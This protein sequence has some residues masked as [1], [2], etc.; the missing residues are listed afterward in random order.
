MYRFRVFVCTPLFFAG[1]M[2]LAAED[3]L[4]EEILVTAQRFEENVRKVPISVS[5][6]TDAMI[7]DRQ[8]IGISD[9]QLNVPNLSYTPQNFGG[10]RISIRGIGDLFTGGS[11]RATTVPIH[12]NG[13]TALVDAGVFEFY[14]LERVEVSRGPQGTL[15]GRNATAGAINLVT[16]RPDFDGLG[17]Y[18]DL[19]YGDYDHVRLEGALNL[20][21]NDQFAIRVAGVSLERDG[22]IENK[23]GLRQGQVLRLTRADWDPSRPRWHFIRGGRL[24]RYTCSAT[25]RERQTDRSYGVDAR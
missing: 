2:A 23:T 19:E 8:I 5:A 15:Y 21:I 12:L 16:R 22:Y 11:A 9:L 7:E 18:V 1:A 14:D 24:V 3:Y 10:S 20:A 4:I 25:V 17:G 13:V 6:F